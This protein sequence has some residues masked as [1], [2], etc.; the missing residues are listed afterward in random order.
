V[1]IVVPKG[2][3]GGGGLEIVGE[4]T[5]NDICSSGKTDRDTTK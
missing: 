5:S 1:D 3:G 4:G 2:G